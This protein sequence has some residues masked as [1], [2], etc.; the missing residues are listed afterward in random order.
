MRSPELYRVQ[1]D[2]VSEAYSGNIVFQVPTGC[3]MQISDHLPF[4][5]HLSSP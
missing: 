3:C 2:V 1:F 4:S 5:L